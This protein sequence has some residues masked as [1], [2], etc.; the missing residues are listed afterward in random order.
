MPRNE[1][2]RKQ[3]QNYLGRMDELRDAYIDIEALEKG[4]PFY[5]ENHLYA[6]EW[7]KIIP[8]ADSPLFP[9][10]V[11]SSVEL[12]ADVC[13]DKQVQLTVGSVGTACADKERM[14]IIILP[15]TLLREAV[16]SR[17]FLLQDETAIMVAATNGMI[18]HEAAHLIKSPTDI[19]EARCLMKSDSGA[20]PVS[21]PAFNGFINT[22]ED[23]YIEWWLRE[24]YPNLTP[25]V[26][27]AHEF[28]FHEADLG[29]R[30]HTFWLSRDIGVESYSGASFFDILIAMKNWR[31]ADSPI[32]KGIIKEYNEELKCFRGLDKLDDR[33]KAMQAIWRKL[34]ADS[35]L[36]WPEPG[37]HRDKSSKFDSEGKCVGAKMAESMADEETTARRGEAADALIEEINKEL[38][39]RNI[40]I[41]IKKGQT[42]ISKIPPTL[43]KVV[44]PSHDRVEPDKRFIPLAKRLRSVLTRNYAPGQ[45]VKRGPKL[46]ST[47]LQRIVTDG[48]IF[49][50][51]ETRKR[52]GRDFEIIILVDCSGSM[53]SGTP[54]RIKEAMSVGV[55]AYLSLRSARVRT[56][57]LGHTSTG[58]HRTGD[59]ENPILYVFGEAKDVTERVKRRAH[60]AFGS[61]FK[62]NNYDGFAVEKACTFFSD[63][64]T[65]KWLIV[66]SDGQPAGIH[67]DGDEAV[68]HSRLAVDR[69]RDKGADVVSITIED[70]AYEVNDRIYGKGKN[71]HTRSS[72]ALLDLVEAMF[73]KYKGDRNGKA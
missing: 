45:P 26:E 32:W 3:L 5:D 56:V 20:R 27:A 48:K 18:V 43:V 41:R 57:L 36:R 58:R 1:D 25:F 39:K 70:G 67:Y 59:D 9:S 12:A 33:L 34:K 22:C 40:V 68:E 47:R 63:R 65:K 49:T 24:E 50:Y 73:T 7:Y 51:P 29:Q 30:L 28:W 4:L 55:A 71:I 64:P 10:F 35:R 23:I 44:E 2:Q 37:L 61:G 13:Q 54:P 31:F 53:A 14:A 72:K 8:P 66:I 38:N 15:H 62:F 46:V 42:D 69:A 11:Y 60:K 19:E 21:D 16:A 17:G 6:K 52:T